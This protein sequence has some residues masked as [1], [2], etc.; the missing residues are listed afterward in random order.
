[1]KRTLTSATIMT[2]FLITATFVWAGGM[3]GGMGGGGMMNSNDNGRMGSDRYYDQ[4]HDRQRNQEDY[5]HDMR[6]LDRQIRDNE[7]ALDAESQKKSPD[8]AKI[9]KLRRELSELEHRYDK[10]RAEFESRW[11]QDDRQ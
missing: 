4:D 6:R 1:M 3:G 11:G 10:R 9:E 5:D 2:A 7:Q 8:K